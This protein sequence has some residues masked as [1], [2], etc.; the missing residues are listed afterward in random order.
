M[1]TVHQ[2]L[3]RDI[4]VARQ[5]ILQYLDPHTVRVCSECGHEVAPS[6]WFRAYEVKIRVRV[7]LEVGSGCMGIAVSELIEE[8]YI[9]VREVDLKIRLNTSRKESHGRS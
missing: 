9:E 1:D 6:K 8:G 4:Q 2:K 7:G 3:R 5:A